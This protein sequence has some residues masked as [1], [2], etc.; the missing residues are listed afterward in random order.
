MLLK[1]DIANLSKNIYIKKKKNQDN[2][3]AVWRNSHMHTIKTSKHARLKNF[4]ICLIPK[5]WIFM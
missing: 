4:I 2:S 5:T 1:F 3:F